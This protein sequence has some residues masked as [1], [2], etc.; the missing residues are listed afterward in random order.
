M[1]VSFKSPV[2]SLAYT[3]LLLVTC[4]TMARK[5]DENKDLCEPSACS[6]IASALAVDS[7][8][9]LQQLSFSELHSRLDCVSADLQ[10]ICMLALA[11]SVQSNCIQ[12]SHTATCAIG[13]QVNLNAW[14]D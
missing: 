5:M 7:W 11:R 14:T 10:Q 3:T 1:D 12:S 8:L 13:Y 9:F 6:C 4:K 2:L